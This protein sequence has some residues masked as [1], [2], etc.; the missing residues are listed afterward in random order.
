MYCTRCYSPLDGVTEG[1]CPRCGLGFDPNVPTSF[2]VR[3]F[4][5]GRRIVWHLLL[6]TIICIVAAFVVALHQLVQSSGH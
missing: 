2:L 5:T 3:P 4:P 1:R 6:T